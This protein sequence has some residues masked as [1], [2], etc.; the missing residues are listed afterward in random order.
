MKAIED[1]HPLYVEVSG[2]DLIL[3][4]D[5]QQVPKRV[6]PDIYHAL[7]DVAHIPFLIYLRLRPLADAGHKISDN[8]AAELQSISAKIEAA[9]EA[10]DTGHFDNAQLGRQNLMI[11]SS[12]K[13]LHETVNKKN[14]DPTDLATFVSAMVPLMMQ[15]SNEA[16]CV[17]V[18]EMHAQMMRWKRSLSGDE[19]DRLIVVNVGGHQPRYRN[20]ATQYF[21]WL[22]DSRSPRWGYPGESAR[23]LYEESRPKDETVE[24]E[25]AAISLDADVSRALLN[26]RWRLSEDLLSD[27]AATCIA[28]LPLTDR[29]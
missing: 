24:D 28:K 2:N 11:E 19:R 9:R 22:F 29:F 1:S 21:A 18:H 5:G 23:V 15:N 17:Q 27:G 8:E 20:V 12:I 13:L 26:D 10:L 16:A 3:H 7:K 14:V 25:L 6:L 4:R